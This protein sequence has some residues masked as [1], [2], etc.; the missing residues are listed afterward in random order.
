MIDERSEVRDNGTVVT[1]CVFLM[2]STFFDVSR[3][4]RVDSLFPFIPP[5]IEWKAPKDFNAHSCAAVLIKTD[6]LKPPAPERKVAS[7]SSRT[8]SCFGW[9][10]CT[11][12]LA[13]G[14]SC[15]GELFF[16]GFKLAL[17]SR[18]VSRSADQYKTFAAAEGLV[19]R[20]S[21]VFGR[22]HGGAD[23][24]WVVGGSF[25]GRR[26]TACHR[27]NIFGGGNGERRKRIFLNVLAESSGLKQPN[28]AILSNSPQMK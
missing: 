6:R 21:Y 27:C 24:F 20:A 19:H 28:V 25:V 18:I 11:G 4:Q 15:H 7:S 1:K 10:I 2:R 23:S 9:G 17:C 14:E 22:G 13:R 12:F 8:R 26:P 16:L 3:S 5:P